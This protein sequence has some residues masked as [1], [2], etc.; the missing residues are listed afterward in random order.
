MEIAQAPESDVKLFRALQLV[1]E[2]LKFAEAK[3]GVLVTFNGAAIVGIHNMV[4]LYKVENPWGW[5]WV[6]VATACCFAS[7][8]VGLSS[9]YARTNI[10]AFSFRKE[11]GA[12]KNG[13]YFGHLADMSKD[14]VLN[15]LVRQGDVQDKY[16]RDMAGQVIINAKLARKKMGLFN[17][18]LMLTVAGAVTPPLAL[19]Y[20]WGLCDDN[21]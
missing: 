20:Y 15:E 17:V 10:M 1:N 6:W 7:L 14:Q 21:T 16:L 12:R 18:A 2:W 13:I 3:N 5:L 9:F 8:A 4:S 19:L 11:D